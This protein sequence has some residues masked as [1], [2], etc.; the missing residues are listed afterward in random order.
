MRTT[1]LAQWFTIVSSTLVVLSF[2]G[3]DDGN[4]SRSL[5][6]IAQ[7]LGYGGNAN[8]TSHAI[9]ENKISPSSVRERG[10]EVK[11]I[12]DTTDESDCNGSLRHPPTV[13]AGYAYF[14]TS[15]C[16]RDRSIED[17]YLHAVDTATGL[18]AWK[19]SMPSYG[20]GIA[21]ADFEGL[22]V[23]VAPAVEEDVLVI[24]MQNTKSISFNPY[25]RNEVGDLVNI[26][27]ESGAYILSIDRHTGDLLWATEIETHPYGIITQSPT[28]A[29]DIIY[30]GV[31]TPEYIA[32]F[33]Q[34]DSTLNTE[35]CTARG[36]LV[37]LDLQTGSI[38][39]KTYMTPI[40]EE[41]KDKVPLNIDVNFYTGVSVWGNQP[42]VDTKRNLVYVATGNNAGAPLEARL[43]ERKRRS[44]NE[45]KVYGPEALP[46]EFSEYDLDISLSAEEERELNGLLAARSAEIGQGVVC[47]AIAG[48][49]ESGMVRLN[50]AYRPTVNTEG[51]KTFGNYPDA[52]VA[53]HTID[54]PEMSV[55][56]GDVAWAFRSVE[57]D[58]FRWPL[59]AVAGG[60]PDPFGDDTDFGNGPILVTTP[61]GREQLIASSKEQR[62]Y[63]IDP[64]TGLEVWSTRINSRRGFP[65]W[66]PATDGKS[67][68]IT[69]ITATNTQAPAGSLTDPSAAFF[70][71]AF[72]FSEDADFVDFPNRHV[73]FLCQNGRD[74]KRVNCSPALGTPEAILQK[75]TVGAY[76]VALDIETGNILWEG[77]VDESGAFIDENGDSIID[78]LEVSH[79]L[80]GLTIANGVLFGGTGD[81][82]GTVQARDAANGEV[83]WS[84]TGFGS[85]VFIHP[86]VADGVVYWGSGY[87]SGLTANY[88]ENSDGDKLIA[89]ELAPMQ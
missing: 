4:D 52:I 65:D 71:N 3:C 25:A 12:Y 41:D 20:E 13:F 54:K 32:Q 1:T 18:V 9:E 24:G 84:Y 11:W 30:V 76:R 85:P 35:C 10:L 58:F 45:P 75:G 86:A 74:E 55:T 72:D 46:A 50:D 70:N 29:N 89:F 36:S 17:G 68:Y 57:Y 5:N 67:V 40:K 82:A 56:A 7:W 31:S 88:I 80:G 49:N 37:A 69:A 63:A 44:I 60:C 83:I 2:S 27:P 79:S 64:D 39:W 16:E 81:A 59:C 62:I 15:L 14:T 26:M 77:A 66:N 33:R 61:S 73:H 28:I 53:L 23:R 21:N 22:R 78:N 47:G 42:V 8:N 6:Q 48:E 34:G 51:E 38:Q 87:V 19:R 43:C